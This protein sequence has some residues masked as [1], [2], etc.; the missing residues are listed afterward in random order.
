MGS[1]ANPPNIETTTWTSELKRSGQ[2]ST[3]NAEGGCR[4]T[5]IRDP[6]DPES[7]ITSFL[8]YGLWYINVSFRNMSNAIFLSV[9]RTYLYLNT[10]SM[11]YK[12]MV[13]KGGFWAVL[14]ILGN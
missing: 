7:P 3:T 11:A 9:L 1:R 8:R 14:K 2:T 4:P 10:L 5:K 6:E 12:G 13:Y